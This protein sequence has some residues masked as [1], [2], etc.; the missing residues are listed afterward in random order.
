VCMCGF[1]LSNKNCR[2]YSYARGSA[3]FVDTKIIISCVCVTIHI[4]GLYF[5]NTE[6][7]R[8]TVLG[9]VYPQVRDTHKRN[10]PREGIY[11]HSPLFPSL[12]FFLL[13]DVILR[14]ITISGS[15]I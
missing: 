12:S 15:Q 8:V 10:S 6:D 13:A 2:L 14:C 5:H 1:I 11:A 3:L 9:N 7:A 4:G